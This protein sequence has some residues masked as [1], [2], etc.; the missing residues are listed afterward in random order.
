MPNAFHQ[1]ILQLIRK[2]SKD[3]VRDNSSAGYLGNDH[4][5]YAITNP[6]LRVIAKHWIRAHRD[7]DADQFVGLTDSLI[8]GESYT[9]KLMAGILLGY[10][11]KS[12]RKFDPAI[13]D[14]WLQHLE[15]WAEV[16]SVCTGDYINAQLPSDWSRWK[17]LINK[18]SKDKNI[19]KQRASLVLFCSPL[20]HVKDDAIAAVALQTVTRLKHEK[21]VMI[22]KAISWV[23]RSMIR[24]YR[25]MVS[26]FLN[27]NA[28]TLPRIAVRETLVK[29]KTGKK[30]KRDSA[31]P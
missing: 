6:A 27:E 30:T 28:E 21:D 7:L 17:K 25:E 23:L 15:G 24:H 16:D 1:E 22:T 31:K 19:N 10:S 11:S 14:D 18:F 5:R 29:L 13:F 8:K 9:E 4:P 20:S 12:Q 26:V 3:T 2:N